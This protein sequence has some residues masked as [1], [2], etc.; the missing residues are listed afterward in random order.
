MLD[1][2]EAEYCQKLRG[3]TPGW[4]I[5]PSLTVFC[6]SR[7]ARKIPRKLCSKGIIYDASSCSPIFQTLSFCRLSKQNLLFIFHKPW[8]VFLSGVFLVFLHTHL[9]FPLLQYLLKRC[10]TTHL[11]GVITITFLDLFWT[12]NFSS[13]I[14]FPWKRNWKASPFLLCVWQLGFYGPTSFLWHAYTWQCL[15]VLSW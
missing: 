3:I 14:L 2:S 15:T 1:K 6:S 10:S 4:T 7:V 8:L 11:P 5:E 13:F 12:W 9:K